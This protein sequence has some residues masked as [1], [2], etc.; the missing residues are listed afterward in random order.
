MQMS[1]GKSKT[2]KAPRDRNTKLMRD[3]GS[4]NGAYDPEAPD[5]W[6]FVLNHSRCDTDRAMAWIKSKTTA[7]HHNSPFCVDEHGKALRAPHLAVDLGWELQTAR[8]V[9]SQLGAQGRARVDA[10]GRIW[11]CADVPAAHQPR[12]T[13][14]IKGDGPYSVQSIFEGYLLDSIRG[15]PVEQR[16]LTEARYRAVQK[17]TNDRIAEATAAVRSMAERY[18]DTIL[19]DVGI[20]KKRLDKKDRENPSQLKLKLVEEPNF[21]Q[22][23]DPEFVQTAQEVW[24]KA[25]NGSVQ[26]THK[27]KEADT[28]ADL[29]T[30]RPSSSSA[31]I[32][33]VEKKA[34]EE[35]NIPDEPLD[36]G[37]YQEIVN[38]GS[39][40][41][42]R[43]SK[44]SYHT[45]KHLYPVDRLDEPKARPFFESLSATEKRICIE[46]LQVYLQCDRWIDQNGRWIPLASNWLKSYQAEPPPVLRKDTGRASESDV[47]E[48]MKSM[49]RARGES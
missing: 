11:Q 48:A 25:E 1:E 18:E 24:Y 23:I 34:E 30:E 5:Q 10:R 8:N 26:G 44:A 32:T 40:G 7:H 21:V 19:R 12:S 17:W 13:G 47:L 2:E 4:K 35:D 37:T 28:D 46:R 29:N 38:A 41:E 3:M 15:L 20:K 9:L 31:V 42:I 45:F 27:N 6:L 33:K 14:R 22:S 49:R 43:R 16:V 39:V 36:S